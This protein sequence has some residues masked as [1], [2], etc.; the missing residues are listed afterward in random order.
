M[1]NIGGIKAGRLIC[2]NAGATLCRVRF[3][4]ERKDLRLRRAGASFKRRYALIS[5]RIK[6]MYEMP[7][8]TATKPN[9]VVMCGHMRI[10]L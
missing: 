5:A 9:M 4:K 6:I 3:A 10:K 8:Q 7:K 1:R 2:G